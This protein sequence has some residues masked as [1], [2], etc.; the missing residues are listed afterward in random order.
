M[1]V[2]DEVFCSILR[3]NGALTVGDES[4]I[5]NI[6]CREAL[7]HGIEEDSG[8]SLQGHGK[9]DK[10]VGASRSEAMED[11][12]TD[13]KTEPDG[14]D[15]QAMTKE[16]EDDVYARAT[17][18]RQNPTGAIGTSYVSDYVAAQQRAAAAAAANGRKTQTVKRKPDVK[19]PNKPKGKKVKSEPLT[20]RY[21]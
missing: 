1:D 21:V 3:L 15:E 17:K 5:S 13:I 6:L 12:P 8:A 11:Q 16:E 20:F 4:S 2:D 10:D 14:S 19:D 7:W 18:A 9:P